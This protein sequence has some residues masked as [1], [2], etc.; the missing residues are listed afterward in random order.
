MKIS[1]NWL[2]WYVPEMPTPE[3]LAD[4]FTYHLC[5]VES[6]EKSAD[7]DTLFDLNILP[8]R[9]HDL[10][11]VH[12][13]AR[14]LSGQLGI[15][16]KDPS[17]YYKTPPLR[18]GSAGQALQIEIK[19]PNCR[20]YMSRIVRNITVG[21][22]PEWV[23]KHLESIGQ[24]SINNVVD[25]T[26]LCMFDCG[27]PMHVFDLKKLFSE[28]IVIRQA[29]EGETM[30]TLDD[31]H[32]ALKQSDMVIADESEIL[33]LAGVKGGTNAE[34]EDATTD[35]VLEVANFEPVTVRKTARRLGIFTDAAKRFENDLSP[36]LC[37]FGMKELTGLFIEMCPDAIFEDVVDVYPNPQLARTLSF[38][39]DDVNKKLGTTIS[40]GDVEAILKRYGYS[41]THT[42]S[43]FTLD[44]SPLRLD[45]V[46]AEDMVEEIGRI[47][48]YDSVVPAIPTINFTPKTNDTYARMCAAREKLLAEGYSEVMTY[49]F[50]KKGKVEIARG[51]KGKEFLRTNLADGL[52][53]SYEM[54]R[55]NAP[56]LGVDEAK[57]FEIGAVFPSNGVE[58][59]HVAVGGKKGITEMPLEDF[60][61]E[62]SLSDLDL[63]I[64]EKAIRFT[65]WSNFPFISRDV[66]V[67]V[68]AGTHPS[69]LIELCK[70]H[71]TELLVK[72]PW[73]FD[74][75]T[76]DGKTSF[77][78]RLIFQSHDRTLT[79]GEV[80]SIMA[81][82]TEAIHTRA[83]ELR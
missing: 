27:Q 76:K 11:S 83:W 37:E 30:T 54:N 20:R 32:V 10:L 55:L 33:A 74:Q 17:G 82:I 14:E 69:E 24:R 59:I 2:K 71:G 40:D 22:S 66:A 3:K 50:G 46:G 28:K 56:L 6:M 19:T 42:A 39:T 72:E 45:L 44:V 5:E 7:G 51:A 9:A 78:V 68:P 58:K 23:V 67:W 12:G 41:Y 16:F 77:A 63:K 53:I 31:K 48:G 49:T 18:Q 35:I 79:D 21:P 73:L 61:K 36:T 70:E 1:Y 25:A 47:I 4:V 65:P 43:R 38:S 60:S 62:L 75:F 52:A 81:H 57:I 26:N 34:V 8:N 15:E 64:S 13:I 80:A 29:L